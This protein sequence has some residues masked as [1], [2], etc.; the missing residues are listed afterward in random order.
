MRVLFTTYPEKAHLLMMVPLAWALR[1][2]GHEVQVA[3]QPHFVDHVTQAGLTAVPIGSERDLWQL[4]STDDRWISSGINGMPIPYDTA[5]WRPE[6]VTMS[7]L[8]DGYET[9]VERWHQVSTT[10]ML[11]GLVNYCRQWKPDLV[12]W[13]PLTYAGPIAAEACGAAH[14][15]LVFGIDSLAITREHF[16]RLHAQEQP[17]GSDPLAEMLTRYGERYGV[18]YSET[19]ATGQF[20]FTLLPSALHSGAAGL[21]YEPL[22]FVPYGGPAVIPK[23]LWTRPEKPRVAFTMGISHAQLGMMYSMELHDV[24]KELSRLDIEVVA[25]VPEAAQRE[26]EWVPD[27]V[28]MV[29]YVP[30]AALVPTCAVVVHH[31][32]FGT[33]ATTALHGVPQIVVP[34]D[35]DGPAL[36]QRVAAVGAGFAIHASQADGTM[37]RQRITRIFDEDALTVGTAAL[38]EEMLGMPSPTEV[39]DQIEA[40]VETHCGAR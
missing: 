39:A 34:W 36:A 14:A 6:T 7:Y 38:R 32:G 4:M 17:P 8:R 1:T 40:I 25:T 3:V 35:D 24:F 20:T 5:D 21:K 37:L 2:A 23:W 18:R 30:L 13:E 19:L 12:I 26:L 15:R 29:P 33:L 10:P 28:R 27:N 22:R 16:L 11:R 9:Q 31:G